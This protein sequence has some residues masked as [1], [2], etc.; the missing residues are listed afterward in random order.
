MDENI[1]VVNEN[2]DVI[3]DND[4]T[5]EQKDE[6]KDKVADVVEKIR[7]QALLLGAR[8]MA[9]TIANMI[10]GDINKPGKRSMADMRR[11]VKKVR[12]FCQT[13]IN[14]TVETPNFGEEEEKVD[15]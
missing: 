14:H 11:I 8:T 2:E 1:N 10:D 5:D 12:D 3:V 4:I 6:F 15:E 7:T 9:V 13:A